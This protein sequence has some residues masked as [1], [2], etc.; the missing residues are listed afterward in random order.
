MEH[1]L[2]PISDRWNRNRRGTGPENFSGRRR[3]YL[4]FGYVRET[5][6]DSQDIPHIRIFHEKTEA[7]AGDL[8]EVSGKT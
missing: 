1:A 7:A 5:Y 6:T 3:E 4:E 2:Q 8:W